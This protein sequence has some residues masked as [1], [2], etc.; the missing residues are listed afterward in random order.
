MRLDKANK[1]TFSGVPVYASDVIIEVDV[2]N[3]GTTDDNSFGV[4]CRANGDSYYYMEATS[5]GYYKIARFVEDEYSE[6]V[7]WTVTTA[8]RAGRTVNHLRVE[9]VTNT[10]LFYAN[11]T[12]LSQ[13]R[14]NTFSA[15]YI[16]LMAGSFDTPGVDVLFDNFS[17]VAPAAQGSSTP[18]PGPQP[19]FSDFVFAEDVTNDGELINPAS[20][21]PAG[22]TTVWAYFDHE[23]MEDGR[24]WGLL[25]ERDGEPY[26]DMRNEVWEDGPSGWL[27]YGLTEDEGL[28]GHFTLTLFVGDRPVQTGSFDVGEKSAL[29]PGGSAAFGAI[30]F[31]EDVT[32]EGAPIGTG[33]DFDAGITEV[34]AVFPFMNMRDGRSWSR[35]WLYE[36]EC[37]GSE[38]CDVGRRA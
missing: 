27:A 23:N 10:L 15:G 38:G 13:V 32:E 9:C 1:L 5:D 31:S 20:V 30:Q 11:G 34:Y 18:S 6:L 22:T 25:W 8:I 37:A 21:F 3:V 12:L 2:Q 36:G 17:A 33:T 29:P 14:D 16:G 24:A 19:T 28:N 26:K 4:Y 7:P 35:E